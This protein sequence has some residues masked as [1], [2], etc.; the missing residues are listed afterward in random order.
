MKMT[1]KRKLLMSFSGVL[2]LLA[3]I[4]AITYVQF[5]STDDSYTNVIE[6]RVEKIVLSTKM[7]DSI[8][9]EQVALRGYLVND[10]DKYLSVFQESKNMFKQASDKY[11]K[12]NLD[13]EA[14]DILDELNGFA[15]EY[16]TLAGKLIALKD[17]D[18]EKAYIDLMNKQGDPLTVKLNKASEEAINYQQSALLEKSDA[19]SNQVNGVKRVILIISVVAIIAGFSIALIINRNISKPVLLVSAAAEEI[20]A[21]NLTIEDIQVTNKDEIGELARS[22]NEMK[23]NLRSLIGTVN[24]ATEQVAASS[25]ELM[26]SAEQTNSATTQVVTAIQQVASGAEIQNNYVEESSNGVKVMAVGTKKVALTTSTVTESAMEAAKQANIGSEYLNKV[27]EQMKSIAVSTNDS[28]DVVK[29][30]NDRSNEIGKIIEVITG[31]ADQTN[32]LA[33]NAAIESARAGEHGKGFAVVADEVK[34]LA[35]QSRQSANQIADLIQ[36]I[37]DDTVHVVKTMNH[38][39]EEVTEG[40]KLV[41]E[42]GK[43]FDFIL[44][45]IETV[46]SEIQE[47]SAVSE[48]MAASVDQ[49]SAAI[50]QVTRITEGSVTSTAEIASA[51]EE[52]LASMEEIT[53]SASSL[54]KMAEEL[55]EKVVAFKI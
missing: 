26:A 31:I 55:K 33:L 48:E 6:N 54:A 10:T 17:Q 20:A 7:V 16:E 41:E 13:P 22:F 3:I 40:M 25:E 39:T 37:Q 47:A 1:V 49:V 32:L 11:S 29:K 38:G 14:K 42:T 8:R 51:S 5:N 50:E 34:K 4:T 35:E 36:D 18:D 9:K 15:A 24:L 12:L 21:G 28:N 2:V 46:S 30:L 45:S 53:A 52:Q 19:L 44:E 23:G 27:I 43:T